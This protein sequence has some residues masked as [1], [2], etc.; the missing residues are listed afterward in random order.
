MNIVPVILGGG[1]GSR[2]WP[3][4]RAEYP[5][6]YN[7]FFSEDSLFQSTLRRCQYFSNRIFGDCK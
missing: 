2:L 6:Q 5:K 3:L 1:V 4:S 7:T